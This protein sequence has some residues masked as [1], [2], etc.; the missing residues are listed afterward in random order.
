MRIC[1]AQPAA[2]QNGTPLQVTLARGCLHL[3]GTITPNKLSVAS[4]QS[5]VANLLLAATGS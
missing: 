2:A 1:M 3:G 5:A 4:K